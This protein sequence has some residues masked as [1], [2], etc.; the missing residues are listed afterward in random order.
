MSNSPDK[1]KLLELFRLFDLKITNVSPTRVFFHSSGVKHE[2]KLDYLTANVDLIGSS[3]LQ[4]NLGDHLAQ[5]YTF[6]I[7]A[8]YKPP[9]QISFFSF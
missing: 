7:E 3:V 2:Q 4:P 1:H 5:I 9:F 6:K 8:L